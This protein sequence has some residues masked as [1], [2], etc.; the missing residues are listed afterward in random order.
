MGLLA[1]ARGVLSNDSGI[2][3]LAAAL[4]TPVVAVFG[5]THP[6]WT[7]PLGRRTPW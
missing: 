7:A 2:M 6:G 3:H 5:S 1:R 4:G